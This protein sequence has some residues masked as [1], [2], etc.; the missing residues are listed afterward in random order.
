MLKADFPIFSNNPD[1]VYLDSAAT[2]QKPYFV[3]NGVRDFLSKHN[4]NIHRWHYPLAEISEELYHASKAKVAQILNV[5]SHEII[6]TYNA[7]YAFNMLAQSLHH[8]NML[9]KGDKVLVLITEHHANIVPWQILAEKSGIVLEFV[10]IDE[11]RQINWTD[12][13]K[14]YDKTV[15]IVSFQHVSNVTGAIYDLQRVKSMLRPDTL[16]FVD[17]AQAVPHFR[18]DVQTLG[19]DALVFT[20]HKIFAETWIGVLYCKKELQQ[21]LTPARGGGGIVEEVTMSTF[22]LKNNREK[23]EPGTPN[24]IGAVSLL[25][26]FEYLDTLGGYPIMSAE[27]AISKLMLDGFQEREVS[28]QLY[29]PQQ[30]EGRIGVYSFSVKSLQNSILLGEH[31]W[32]RGI[33]VR[34]WA[35]C[36]HP[37]FARLGKL[38][39]CRASLHIYNDWT[40]VQKFFSALDDLISKSK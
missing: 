39:A 22:R 10:D 21:Q 9:Q 24:I 23:F 26:A 37:L 36:A 16:F 35:H 27:R 38:G 29:G 4:A 25:K 34:S 12:F 40:D 14:K 28:I 8:S 30:L 18:V 20:G 7:T 1:L 5:K 2:S 6:Y 11:N 19:C 3:I 17:A 31:L 15:K 32:S 13:E 33:C